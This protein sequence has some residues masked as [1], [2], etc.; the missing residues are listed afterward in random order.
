M[1]ARPIEHSTAVEL[2]TGFPAIGDL[3]LWV[4][5]GISTSTGNSAVY[6]VG[7]W[8]TEGKE[9]RQRVGAEDIIGPGNC[10]KIDEST[11]EC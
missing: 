4:P 1:E 3:R 11:F 10:P 8:V 6:P 5:E 7:T 2:A 9:L